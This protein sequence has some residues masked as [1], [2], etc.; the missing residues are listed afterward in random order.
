MAFWNFAPGA[1]SVCVVYGALPPEMRR[2]Q[3]RLFND[4]GSG[5]D[6]LVA[7]DAVGMGLNLNIRRI[8]FHTLEKSEGGDGRVPISVS[9]VKQIAGAP[10]N[11]SAHDHKSLRNHQSSLPPGAQQWAARP[12]L[13]RRSSRL[14]VRSRCMALCA[15][16]LTPCA[17]RSALPVVAVSEEHMILV[18]AM[19]AD[20]AQVTY[21]CSSVLCCLF[22][23]TLMHAHAM[24]GIVLE[25]ERRTESHM[26]PPVQGARGGA[27]ASGARAW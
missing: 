19:H 15:H 25:G 1:R 16:Y 5:Y 22:L 10:R 24:E 14:P 12:S 27:T 18:P 2:T 4:P 3:A 17:S 11:P 8:I 6:V 13:C 7:S 23:H 9:Q 21:R 26:L 20:F